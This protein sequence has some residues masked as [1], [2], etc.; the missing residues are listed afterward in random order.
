[1]HDAA[2]TKYEDAKPEA[3]AVNDEIRAAR[4]PGHLS[5]FW[6]TLAFHPPT[7][8]RN[9][10]NAKGA[11]APGPLDALTK[12]MLWIAASVYGNCDFSTK[13]HIELA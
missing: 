2:I 6:K 5:D 4:G 12:E 13:A 3:R 7:L 8:R 9:W 1:M 10:E 11:L